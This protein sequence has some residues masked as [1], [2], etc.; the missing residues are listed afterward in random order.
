MPSRWLYSQGRGTERG[1]PMQLHLN[2]PRSCSIPACHNPYRAKGFC[3]PHY[4]RWRYH[5][6][7]LAGGLPVT[8]TTEERF[9]HKVDVRGPEECWE[10]KASL[11]TDGYGMFRH[12]KPFDRMY[13]A[14]RYA[15]ENLIGPIPDGLQLDHL[16]RNHKCVNPR[17]LEPVTL[18]ENI[19]RGVA[20]HPYCRWGHAFSP[21]NTRLDKEGHRICKKCVRI[22]YLRW[23]G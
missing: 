19:R 17:H 22:R 20:H 9:W 8:A 23:K 7:P 6:D 21:L 2:I 12:R 4:D 14:H 16:Y 15:Y 5:G 1:L 18:L 3:S 11:D 10:W 13:G